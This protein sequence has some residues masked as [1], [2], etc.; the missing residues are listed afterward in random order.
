M[1]RALEIPSAALVE[2][3]TAVVLQVGAGQELAGLPQHC[4]VRR[5]GQL[6]AWY[7]ERD[8]VAFRHFALIR[9]ERAT[10]AEQGNR[11]VDRVSMNWQTFCRWWEDRGTSN[12]GIEGH[13]GE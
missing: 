5:R 11:R 6:D 3:W 4:D 12:V 1:G 2:A 7:L 13:C 10:S 8:E 9:L